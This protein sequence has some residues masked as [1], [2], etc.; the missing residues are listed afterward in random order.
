MKF[1]SFNSSE[2][3]IDICK[4][5]KTL[6]ERGFY[7]KQ[8]S[9]YLNYFS[10]DKVLIKIYD[11]KERDTLKFIQDIYRFLK[12]DSD[13]IPLSVNIQ[14]KQGGFEN[15]N[16]LLKFVS[17]YIFSKYTPNKIKKCIQSCGVINLCQAK[18]R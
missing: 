10:R 12:I 4:N 8:L 16:V 6:I 18:M 7:F 5:D 13:F 17:R 9:R 14:T 11:D 2:S 15:K 3:I 1:G